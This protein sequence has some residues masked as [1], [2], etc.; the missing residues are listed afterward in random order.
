MGIVLITEVARKQAPKWRSDPARVI[1]VGLAFL[2]AV[3]LAACGG[4]AEDEP[5]DLVVV[6]SFYPLAEAARRVGGPDVTIHNLTPP[7]VEPHDLELAPDDLELILTADVVLYVGAGFQPAVED[8]IADV[9][10]RAVDALEGIQ[11]L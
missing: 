3:S 4:T 9:E 7:G 5:G 6:A 8:A 11:T 10:G 2:V 1:A